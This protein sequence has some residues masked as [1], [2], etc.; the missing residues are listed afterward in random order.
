[1]LVYLC[2]CVSV[3][4]STPQATGSIDADFQVECAMEK[5]TYYV[6]EPM[7]IKTTL[8]NTSGKDQDILFDG[9]GRMRLIMKNE[10]GD[11]VQIVYPNFD[12][13]Q[14]YDAIKRKIKKA[15]FR[16]QCGYQLWVV[17]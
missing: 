15:R 8:R 9:E 12:Y 3:F 4:L 16:I 2:F 10:K 14:G 5:T 7:F 13:A 17:V 1:M 6:G 11:E